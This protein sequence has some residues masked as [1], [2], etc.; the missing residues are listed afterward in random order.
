M[1][2]LFSNCM[3][4]V[5]E[6]LR[7]LIADQPDMQLIESADGEPGRPELV[8]KMSPDVVV[9]DF[10]KSFR[11]GKE[12]VNRMLSLK[13]DLKIVVLSMQTDSRY[14]CECLEAGVAGY[15]LKDCACEELVEAVRTVA[16][17]RRYV[18][19]SLQLPQ[20]PIFRIP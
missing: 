2:V 20:K 15:V 9:L 17:D 19:P 11:D 18:S 6:E 12:T 7:R 13:P 14:F 4:L 8:E 5:R 10:Q 16:A 1:K 3:H